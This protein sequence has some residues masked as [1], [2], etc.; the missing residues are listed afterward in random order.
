MTLFLSSARSKMFSAY[1][2]DHKALSWHDR[3]PIK[4]YDKG[5]VERLD[6]SVLE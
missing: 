1:Q 2:N 6:L 5:I 4:T 3:L